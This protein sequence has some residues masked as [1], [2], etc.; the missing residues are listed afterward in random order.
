MKL[1][2]S[3]KLEYFCKILLWILF[4][5][6]NQNTLNLGLDLFYAGIADLYSF[7]AEFSTLLRAA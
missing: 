1:I 6:K 7:Q 2:F 4:S 5:E 3:L